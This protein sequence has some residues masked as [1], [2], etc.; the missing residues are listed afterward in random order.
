MLSKQTSSVA[1]NF[2]LAEG[3]SFKKKRSIG[4]LKSATD[5]EHSLKILVRVTFHSSINGTYGHIIFF[6]SEDFPRAQI[7][8]VQV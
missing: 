2:H 3:G 4:K 1:P 6:N 5:E 7:A 8:P